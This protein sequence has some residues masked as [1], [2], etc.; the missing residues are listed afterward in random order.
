MEA[1]NVD[2]VRWEDGRES[3]GDFSQDF[4]EKFGV[5]LGKLECKHSS[6]P[7]NEPNSCLI[8][9][10]VNG[11]SQN[12][13]IESSSIVGGN[14]GPDKEAGMVKKE[15]SPGDETL[16]HPANEESD[17]DSPLPAKR[18]RFYFESDALAL[19]NNPEYAQL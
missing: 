12:D 19:K 7:E 17:A 8:T 18:Q 10:Q 13:C 11:N 14:G 16:V 6:D 3:A 5:L 1:D 4:E 9:K 2:T 15:V